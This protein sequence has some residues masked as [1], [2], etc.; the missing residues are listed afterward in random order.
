[1][2]SLFW[3]RASAQQITAYKK[4]KMMY[5]AKAA[6]VGFRAIKGGNVIDCASQCDSGWFF[7]GDLYQAV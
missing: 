5:S 6:R 7:L 4:M 3:E 2:R 1:M